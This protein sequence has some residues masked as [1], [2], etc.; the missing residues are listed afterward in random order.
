MLTANASSP[1]GLTAHGGREP[2]TPQPLRGRSAHSEMD[3]TIVRA[4]LLSLTAFFGGTH[5]L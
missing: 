5:I 4:A 2:M 3:R 1:H